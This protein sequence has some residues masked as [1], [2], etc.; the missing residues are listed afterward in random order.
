MCVRVRA[1]VCVC[2]HSEQIWVLCLA[3][4]ITEQI[5]QSALIRISAEILIISENKLISFD[6]SLLKR[7]RCQEFRESTTL[8]WTVYL[9]IY[10]YLKSVFMHVYMLIQV[11]IAVR[12]QRL[13][14]KQ[15]FKNIFLFI[16]FFRIRLSGHKCYKQVLFFVLLYGY[17]LVL[18][19]VNKS[20]LACT[21]LCKLFSVQRHKG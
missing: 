1:C 11:L 14:L 3:A 2:V 7:T 18:S 4:A 15:H 9:C 20:I 6:F 12:L 16:I 10:W 8:Y 19:V 17:Q 21:G 5:S 13:Y